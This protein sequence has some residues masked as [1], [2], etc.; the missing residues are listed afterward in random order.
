MGPLVGSSD[1]MTHILQ[2]YFT[3][4]GAIVWL[5]QCQWNNPEGY[6]SNLPVP[7]HIDLRKPCSYFLAYIVTPV[8]MQ[9]SNT[10]VLFA[11]THFNVLIWLTGIILCMH[12]ANETWRY[13]VTLSLIGWA[14]A[15]N[16][17]WIKL[18]KNLMQLSTINCNK[19]MATVITG[20]S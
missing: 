1:L 19:K 13:K 18:H 9:W 6:G 15:K 11:V 10:Y 20:F 14:H 3:G 7:E 4:T 12:T 17:P 16:D 8:N 5:P 2:D